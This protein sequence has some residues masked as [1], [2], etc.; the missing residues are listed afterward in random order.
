[1]NLLRIFNTLG[2]DNSSVN[3]A[4]DVR[5]DNLPIDF[6]CLLKKRSEASSV[7]FAL[8]VSQLT[9]RDGGDS[10]SR[11]NTEAFLCCSGG[12]T[13]HSVLKEC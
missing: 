13:P 6:H 8:P 2:K 3:C 12:Y 9:L 7:T 1:V 4:S 5:P 11:D 10:R